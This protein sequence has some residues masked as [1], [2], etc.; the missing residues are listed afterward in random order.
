MKENVTMRSISL[1]ANQNQLQET[2]EADRVKYASQPH[3]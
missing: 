1:Y 3:Q 2:L